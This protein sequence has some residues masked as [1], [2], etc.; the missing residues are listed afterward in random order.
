MQRR[1]LIRRESCPDR[2]GS[3]VVLTA[4]GRAAIEG[5][6]P[7]HVAAVRQTFIEVLTPAEVATLA[8]VSRRVMDHL[9]ASGEAGATPRAS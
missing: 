5:A 1:G 4:Y 2:R 8:A 6:A 7:A 3:D 9:T